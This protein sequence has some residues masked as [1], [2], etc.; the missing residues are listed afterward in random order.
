MGSQK[1]IPGKQILDQIADESGT[2]I[3]V[4]DRSEIEIAVSNNNSIC[5]SLN[6]GG[7]FSRECTAFCGKALE[8]VAE[9][10]GPVSFTC[11][12]GLECRVSPM[13]LDGKPV[14]VIAGRAFARAEN[15]RKATERAISG[16]WHTYLPSQFFDNILLVSS[17]SEIEH[18][19]AR[20][21]AAGIDIVPETILPP[22]TVKAAETVVA[23]AVSQ[24][25]EVLELDEPMHAPEPEP[26]REPIPESTP[27]PKTKP[28]D[29]PAVPK[30]SIDPRKWRSF[31]S[32]LLSRDYEAACEALLE[33]LS[34]QYALE[35]LAWLERRDNRLIG[36]AA[37]GTLKSRKLRLGLPA[38]DPRLAEA[39]RAELPVELSERAKSDKSFARTMYLFP[40][41]V[42]TDVPSAFA[43]L[44]PIE[45]EGKRHQIARLCQWIGPQLEILRLRSEVARRETISLAVRKFGEGLK[46]VDS[47]DFWLHLTQVAAELMQA[48]RGSLLVVDTLT[49]KL[50]IKAAVGAVRDIAE[51]SE[52]GG[53]VA[54]TI[55]ERGAPMVVADVS[56][57]GLPANVS[58]RHY[59]TDSFL[60]API[61]LGGRNI[62]I[63][64]F[65]DKATGAPF[66]RADLDLLQEISPQIA[67][68]VDRAL[69]KEKAGEFQQLS[70]T[71]ALTGLLNRR[72][73]EE[74]LVEEVKRSNRH[75]YPM[76]F[77]LLDVDNFKS[78]NDTYGHPAGDEA[79][80]IVAAILRDTLRGADVAAR[81]GGEEFSILLPQTTIDEAVAIAER[82]RANVEA[83]K[84]PC[85][86][87]T[88]SLGVATCTS[89]L[90][91]TDGIVNAADK[92]LYAA[93]HAGRNNV[94]VAEELVSG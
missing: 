79:L 18:V 90:C 73:I 92:A 86:K 14:A 41:P 7:E 27:G 58:E 34:R 38:D 21:E 74:R 40:V 57:T 11:H 39:V 80:K 71:D 35:S 45:D 56:K 89:E 6:A 82:I 2:A 83:A 64:N 67:V 70:V 13:M 4:V 62:A 77:I 53:R 22:A 33:F 5:R 36:I 10:G 44:D 93:K 26:I 30:V 72:Y 24:D 25:D 81:F 75:G 84:F 50:K 76:S 69:L 17:V 63:I 87:V 52:P 3:A 60:S 48:E 43:V 85:R 94:R 12:A 37:T 20:I 32:S 51:A 15:Y 16:D 66:D 1:E 54:R 61:T 78:Y 42:G 46:H 23:D 9:I 59:K 49:G 65:T 91:T 29:P 68:A 55:L 28:L 8:E 19:A 47:V 31:F 88:V